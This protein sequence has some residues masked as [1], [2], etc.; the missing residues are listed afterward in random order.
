MYVAWRARARLRSVL[1]ELTSV[2][3]LKIFL[4][5]SDRV[6]RNVSS[7]VKRGLCVCVYGGGGNSLPTRLCKRF[8]T[9]LRLENEDRAAPV[10]K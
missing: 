5:S 4:G 7:V 3:R 6:I 1:V 10:Q 8:C 2:A 9:L